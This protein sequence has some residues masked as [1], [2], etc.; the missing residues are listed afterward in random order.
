[1]PI[2]AS[3]PDRGAVAEVWIELLLSKSQGYFTLVDLGTDG[4]VAVLYP[5]DTDEPQVRAGTPVL[6][7]D[8]EVREPLMTAE[9]F[10]RGVVRAFVTPR[11]LVI[12][13]PESGGVPAEAVLRA[14]RDATTDP[15]SGRALPWATTTVQY[16]IVP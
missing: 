7:P 9:P 10:G 13:P 15:V 1:M 11:P 16:N 8:P 5:V 4:T 6:V 12:T 3:I 2:L 14:L